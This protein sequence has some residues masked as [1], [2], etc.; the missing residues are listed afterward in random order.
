[1][2]LE[3][4]IE[5]P[6]ETNYKYEIK[7]DGELVLDRVISMA[8]PFNYGYIPNT[9]CNDGDPLDIFIISQ[10]AIFPKTRA[11]VSVIGGFTC[12][13]NGHQDDKLVGILIGEEECYTGYEVSDSKKFIRHY[14]ENYKTGFVVQSEVDQTDAEMIYIESKT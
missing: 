8:V 10:D 9:M 1:M 14:L 11:K 13:D 4:I 5:I 7:E 6:A 12:I 3:A 2:K